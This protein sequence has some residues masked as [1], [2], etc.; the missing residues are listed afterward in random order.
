MVRIAEF[1][2]RRLT[3]EEAREYLDQ[4]IAAAER[5]EVVALVRWFCDR[6]PTSVER[7]AYVRRAHARWRRAVNRDG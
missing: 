5:E 7:L 2:N 1:A 6:Y 3:E 4:P